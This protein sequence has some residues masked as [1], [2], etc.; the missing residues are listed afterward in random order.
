MDGTEDRYSALLSALREATARPGGEDFTRAN[1][2]GLL[3]I[4]SL[5]LGDDL[6]SKVGELEDGTEVAAEHAVAA[7]LAGLVSALR[8]LDNGLRDPVLKPKTTKKTAGRRWRQRQEDKHLIEAL[9]I[10]TA[11]KKIRRLKPAA[12]QAASLLNKAGHTRCGQR[13]TGES[14]YNLYYRYKYQ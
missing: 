11:T 7:H 4:L 5:H 1:L 3:D 8:D 12:R 10:F 6:A 13:W 9:E 2:I 14:L